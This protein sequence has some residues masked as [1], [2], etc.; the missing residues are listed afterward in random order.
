VDLLLNT[1]NNMK[2]F[3]KEGIDQLAN[4]LQGN[5]N[6]YLGIRPYGF[7]AGNALPFIIYPYLLMDKIQKIGKDVRFHFFIFINDYEQ[8]KIHP[9][10][11]KE[12]PFNI[13][14]LDI[15]FQ[16]SKHR[17]FPDISEV[18]FWEPVIKTHVN[19]LKNNFPNIKITTVRNSDM[20]LNPFFKKCLLTTLK[21]PEDLAN[22]FQKTSPIPIKKNVKYANVVCPRCKFVTGTYEVS[23]NVIEQSCTNCSYESSGNYENYDYWFYHKPLAIPRIQEHNIDLCITGSDHYKEG[24][25]DTRQ[26]LMEYF[27]STVRYPKTLYT[28]TVYAEGYKMGKSKGNAKMVPIIELK[29]LVERSLSPEISL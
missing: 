23:D 13:T 7:H 1:Y 27:E 4:D 24:D 22:I 18:D 11:I 3:F 9:E 6:V 15:T 8:R 5:E 17:E 2:Y 25:F 12:S 20:K 26:D 16:Y 29:K 19:L 14:P 10:S 21:K 28:Q